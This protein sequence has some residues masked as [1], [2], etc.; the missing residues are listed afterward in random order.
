MDP[1][2]SGDYDYK[3]MLLDDSNKK[4]VILFDQDDILEIVSRD[5]E[6]RKSLDS[7]SEPDTADAKGEREKED[8][9]SRK[10]ADQAQNGFFTDADGQTR[11][12]LGSGVYLVERRSSGSFEA[13]YEF[14]HVKSE[15]HAIPFMIHVHYKMQD[16]SIGNEH[17]LEESRF[18]VR[19]NHPAFPHIR[20]IVDTDQAVFVLYEMIDGRSLR[21]IMKKGLKPIWYVVNLSRHI[22]YTM[23]Y[24]HHCQPPL[25]GLDVSPASIMVTTDLDAPIPFERVMFPNLLSVMEPEREAPGMWSN[26]YNAPEIWGNH[27]SPT[28]ESDLYALGCI[29]S[30]MLTG[31]DYWETMQ[32]PLREWN[33][34]IPKGLERLVMKLLEPR[35]ENRFHSCEEVLYW[36]EDERYLKFRDKQE[37][38]FSG[39][40]DLFRR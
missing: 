27:A 26:R 11:I 22:A 30:Y 5:H 14:L 15:P 13:G 18:V 20:D 4:I 29:M 3:G 23:D 37:G 33:P 12:V 28:V 38:L 1:A 2:F 24:L 40:K 8:G 21:S 32:K 31:L 35:P 9:S 10:L 34:E 25:P 17:A 36:L 16:G 39:L 6:K 7:S 19:L